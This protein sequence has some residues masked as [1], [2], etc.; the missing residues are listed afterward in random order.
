MTSNSTSTLLETCNMK[1][2]WWEEGTVQSVVSDDVLWEPPLK[3]MQ[4]QP[5]GAELQTVNF[6]LYSD[7]IHIME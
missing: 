7:G 3:N 5:A 1:Q 2:S 6:S 4:N